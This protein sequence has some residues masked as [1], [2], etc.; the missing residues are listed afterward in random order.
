VNDSPNTFLGVIAVAVLLIA[1][2]QIGVL[3][4]AGMLARRMA[5]T[6]SEIERQIQPLLGH[7]DSI[8]RDAARAA[9]VA[10]A[11][12]ERVDRLFM[13]VT[14]RLD[15]G[16]DAVQQSMHSSLREGAAVWSAIRAAF[17][18]FRSASAT[19]RSRSRADDEDALFI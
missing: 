15:Q 18:A 8:G 19:R 4:V 11:Q 13:D 7:L 6:A 10:S 17:S 12:V 1:I 9:A 2:V 3:I 16:M 14:S 5:R